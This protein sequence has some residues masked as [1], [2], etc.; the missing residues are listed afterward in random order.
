MAKAVGVGGVFLRA[1]DPQALSARY[2]M[3]FG[4]QLGEGGS[5]FFAGPESN[6]MTVF[7]HFPMDT[8]YFGEGAQQEM[9]SFR[10]DDRREIVRQLTE[11]GVWI[12]PKRDDSDYEAICMDFGI[13]TAIAWSCENR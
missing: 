3:H 6:G 5:Q 10:K 12:D 2:T 9:V 1:P 11:A 4:I 13:L 7:P 8:N